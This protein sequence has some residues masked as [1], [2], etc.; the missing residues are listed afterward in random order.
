MD[1]GANF[2]VSRPASELTEV[3]E[4][5][6]A[7]LFEP[8]EVVLNFPGAF[9]WEGRPDRSLPASDD[10]TSRGADGEAGRFNRYSRI[11]SP[12]VMIDNQKMVSIWM[13]RK[14]PQRCNQ[15]MYGR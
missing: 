14:E 10:G 4:L 6:W 1:I 3:P 9:A 15:K 7:A 5:R 2:S 12:T 13:S 8:L 11:L